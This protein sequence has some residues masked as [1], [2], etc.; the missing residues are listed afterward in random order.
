MPRIDCR[1]PCY[2][3]G[4]CECRR[5]SQ[6][7]SCIKL[8]HY[9]WSVISRRVRVLLFRVRSC[10]ATVGRI[11]IDPGSAETF[12]LYRFASIA[13][14]TNK[15]SVTRFSPFEKTL[16]V[17]VSNSVA[18]SAKSTFFCVSS[19]ALRLIF[20]RRACL[21]SPLRLPKLARAA[22]VASSYSRRFSST[23]FR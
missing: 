5:C 2:P 13:S 7:Y 6:S 17:P 12:G 1:S 16:G 22:S 20:S 19:V 10:S 15:S 9:F 21:R 3:E 14:C 23:A 8:V 11:G 4:R 18:L